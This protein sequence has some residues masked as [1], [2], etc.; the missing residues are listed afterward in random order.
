MNRLLT[1]CLAFAISTAAAIADPKSEHRDDQADFVHEAPAAPSEA[2]LLAAGG[3]IY[4]KW[5]EALDREAPVATHPSYPAEG[6]KSGADTWR[7]K[8]CHGWDYR[9]K[10]GRYG[11]GSHYTGIKGIDGAKGRDAADIAQLLRGKLHGYTAEMLLDDELQRIAA[12]VS[13]GQDPTHQ[14]VDPKTA[15]VR[16][17][18]VSGKAIF[19]TVCA[20]CHGFDGRLL[21]FGTV[22]EP[23]YVGTDASALPDE[24]LHKIRNSHPGAAMINMRAFAIEDAVNVLAYA[25]TLPKK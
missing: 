8:E 3:R 14:F 18:A 20:A 13:R 10:D 5:W 12:F 1:A 22:E 7:C 19:Q 11:G 15:K 4:D 9:G 6:K 25:Q 2:W 17:D 24:I 16:G 21:N 23:I